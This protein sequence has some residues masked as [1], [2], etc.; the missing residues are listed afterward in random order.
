AGRW[1]RQSGGQRQCM[2]CRTQAAAVATA[3][4]AAME[5]AGD[6]WWSHAMSHARAVAAVQR[7]DG[8]ARAAAGPHGSRALGRSMP[9]TVMHGAGVASYGEM[10][11]RRQQQGRRAHV[12][13]KL[14]ELCT[15]VRA[16]SEGR[17]EGAPLFALL[18]EVEQ[19]YAAQLADGAA[20]AL[21]LRAGT[22]LVVGGVATA[23]GLATRPQTAPRP[24]PY[25]AR[26]D[27]PSFTCCSAADPVAP[28]WV[29]YL[30][31]DLGARGT[32]GLL[33]A[34]AAAR[35]RGEV[36]RRLRPAAEEALAFAMARRGWPLD[37]LAATRACSYFLRQ[38]TAAPRAHV[39]QVL[40]VWQRVG[41]DV[42]CMPADAHL[43]DLRFKRWNNVA[44]QL[45]RALAAPQR[46]P[47][48]RRQQLL[49]DAWRVVALWHGVWAGVM[50]RVCAPAPPAEGE[51]GSLRP[52][53]R[54]RRPAGGA[55]VHELTLDA[56]AVA[57][58]LR[59]L[60]DGGHGARAADL[61]GHALGAFCVRPTA[62]LFNVVLSRLPAPLSP[63]CPLPRLLPAA[64]SPA[65]A[66]PED[67]H[68]QLSAVVRAMRQVGVAPDGRSLEIVAH[69]CC[70]RGAAE[71]MCEALRVFAREWRVLP[72]ERCWRVIE[73][74][75]RVHAAARAVFEREIA[76]AYAADAG[77]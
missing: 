54:R 37:V 11:R 68:V 70:R 52:A 33:G 59:A 66:L 7:Y 50:R 53:F 64:P 20:P 58:L 5:P 72:S 60:L 40:S 65:F 18:A 43:F 56:L 34:V 73:A 14:D 36:D 2:R 3:A 75:P 77:D 55:R 15:L 63:D 26:G 48:R 23:V 69:A 27:S 71:L 19:R 74:H 44:S 38:R 22:S 10:R 31:G 17:A 45:V 51:A 29:D 61:L 28:S 32:R 16:S 8:Q 46:P 13:A 35:L 12:L 24:T 47:L 49:E 21:L 57:A 30:A 62:S 39:G 9:S 6:E 25:V 41:A 76:P 42:A 4:S 67:P 1:A